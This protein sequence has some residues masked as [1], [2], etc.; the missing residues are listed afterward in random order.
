MPEGAHEKINLE[1]ST[2]WPG[3]G[4]LK[5]IFSGTTFISHICSCVTATLDCMCESEGQG[6]VG[7]VDNYSVVHPGNGRFKA[8][9]LVQHGPDVRVHRQG[10]T[11]VAVV[12]SVVRPS[13]L[14]ICQI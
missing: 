7:L 11:A 9:G 14:F 6:E 13:D 10:G 5:L 1:L 8:E 4:L 2:Y 12:A 3:V